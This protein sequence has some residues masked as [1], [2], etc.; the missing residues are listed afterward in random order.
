MIGMYLTLNVHAPEVMVY[1]SACVYVSV[2]TLPA[3][4]LISTFKL[5]YKQ[6]YYGILLILMMLKLLRFFI[7]IIL[8]NAMDTQ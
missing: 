7:I 8:C 3:A 4:L 1:L 5:R 6:L 2:T